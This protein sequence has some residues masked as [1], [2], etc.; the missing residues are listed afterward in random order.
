M[1][2]IGLTA[3]SKCAYGG[4]AG[5]RPRVQFSRQIASTL[6]YYLY[7]TIWALSRVFFDCE[8]RPLILQVVWSCRMDRCYRSL[9]SIVCCCCTALK[10]LDVVVDLDNLNL[11]R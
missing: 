9:F 2:V 6:Q 10:T 8:Q 4:V 5:Y 3:K 1:S 11:F 7:T